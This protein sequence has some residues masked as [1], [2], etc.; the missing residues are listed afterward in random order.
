MADRNFD[1]ERTK[2][3]RPGHSFTLGGREFRTL[4]EL[5]VSY[6]LRPTSADD[7]TSALEHVIAYVRLLI[8]P[9]QRE[10]FDQMLVDEDVFV[11]ANDIIE[12]SRWLTGVI[13]SSRPT[14][15]SGSSGNGAGRTA[16]SSKAKPSSRGNA[17]RT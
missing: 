4:P 16:R 5:P 17:S 2:N 7:E 9:E 14:N 12:V 8:V 15:A 3:G 1:T 13:S 6:L 11:E 10:A